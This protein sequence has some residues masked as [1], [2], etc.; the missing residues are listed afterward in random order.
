MTEA[1]W[2]K[3]PWATRRGHSVVEIRTTAGLEIAQTAGGHYWQN[4]TDEALANARL[5][6]AAPELYEALELALMAWDH[7]G[8][9]NAI[10]YEHAMELARAA[11]RNAR[12]ES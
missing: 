6:A 5:I 3:G 1:K 4:F 12:G 9:P 11:L 8:E 2:T 10:G 7:D